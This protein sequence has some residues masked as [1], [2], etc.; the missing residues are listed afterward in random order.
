MPILCLGSQLPSNQIST[1]V[2]PLFFQFPRDEYSVFVDR[3]FFF[4][5]AL[6]VSQVFESNTEQ[7]TVYFPPGQWYD[8]FTQEIIISTDKGLNKTLS[9]P[10]DKIQLHVL[11]GN[12]ISMQ[13]P[14]MTTTECRKGAFSLLVALDS[15]QNANGILYLDDGITVDTESFVYIEYSAKRDSVTGHLDVTAV[16]RKKVDENMD[17]QTTNL[18]TV[19]IL[20]ITNSPTKIVL[21]GDILRNNS[22]SFSNNSLK[23]TELKINMEEEWKMEISF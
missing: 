6:M 2:K 23:I 8:W 10:K 3:Q 1:V 21:N 11:G 16:V 7:L 22:Y 19:N 20:G 5:P 15:K 17:L 9:T 13:S 18:G 12:I 4:G 14:G